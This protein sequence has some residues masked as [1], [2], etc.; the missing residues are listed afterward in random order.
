[1]ILSYIISS[2]LYIL[3]NDFLHSIY[4]TSLFVYFYVLII[5]SDIRKVHLF[6]HFLLYNKFKFLQRKIT[7]AIPQQKLHRDQHYHDQKPLAPS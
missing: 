1:M 6:I 4:L 2:T 5:C 3:T 7:L